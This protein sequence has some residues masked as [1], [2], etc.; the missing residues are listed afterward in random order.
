MWPFRCWEQHKVCTKRVRQEVWI[1]S[2][3][4]PI[5]P[6]PDGAHVDPG[7]SQD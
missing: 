5:E 2:T 3:Q 4:A 6:D 7:E 1:Q